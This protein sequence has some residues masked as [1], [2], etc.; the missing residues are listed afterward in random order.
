[1]KT[2]KNIGFVLLLAILGLLAGQIKFAG[3]SLSDRLEAFIKNPEEVREKIPIVVND[4]RRKLAYWIAPGEIKKEQ[5]KENTKI[6]AEL[7]KEPKRRS[8]LGGG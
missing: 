8:L 2:V 3:M 6:E 7:A 1:M 4:S 5:E